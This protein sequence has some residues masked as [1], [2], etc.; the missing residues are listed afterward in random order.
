MNQRIKGAQDF[1]YVDCRTRVKLDK[2]VKM[3]IYNPL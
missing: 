3:K 2:R 1:N